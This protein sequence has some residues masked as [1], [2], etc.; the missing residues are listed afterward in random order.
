M[1]RGAPVRSR[2]A[3]VLAGC[4]ALCGC[5]GVVRYTDAL[6][7][8][9]Y[10]RTWCTRVPAAVGGTLG[11]TL[12]LPLDLL[13]V[14]VSAVVYAN[15]PPATRE[16]LSVFLLPSWVLWKVGLLLGAPFDALEWAVYRA[17]RRD[18]G[19]GSVERE[20]IERAY[21]EAGWRQYPVTPI[22][23]LVPR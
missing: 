7:E 10:G 15:Q 5:A 8:P 1:S 19:L 11:F 16:P 18:P 23:P 17:Y 12:G 2:G 22:H 4:A 20:A 3:A 14:P 6:V 13:G 9:R 21:D